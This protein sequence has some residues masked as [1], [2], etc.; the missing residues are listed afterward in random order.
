VQ[1]V[2]RKEPERRKELEDVHKE[3]VRRKVR[4]RHKGLV[5]HKVQGKEPERHKEQEEDR[6][7]QGRRKVR[8]MGRHKEHRMGHRN[9]HHCHRTHLTFLPSSTLASIQASRYSH[10]PMADNHFHRRNQHSH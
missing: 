4:V 7:E 9:N 10:K 1:V 2:V 5:H 6:K 3:P 8:H